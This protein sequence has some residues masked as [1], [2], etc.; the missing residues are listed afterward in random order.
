MVR[1]SHNCPVVFPGMGFGVILMRSYSE[2]QIFTR[3]SKKIF[4][5]FRQSE[6]ATRRGKSWFY[7]PMA[8]V[9]RFVANMRGLGPSDS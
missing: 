5:L 8:Q 7:N 9:V 1:A 3:R 2:L 4:G 6:F